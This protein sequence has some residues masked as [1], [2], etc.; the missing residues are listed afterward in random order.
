MKHD[1]PKIYWKNDRNSNIVIS[2]HIFD[3]KDPDWYMR[4]I[5]DSREI[6]LTFYIFPLFFLPCPDSEANPVDVPKCTEIS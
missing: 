2:E 1:I 3:N 6:F 5:Y 4:F